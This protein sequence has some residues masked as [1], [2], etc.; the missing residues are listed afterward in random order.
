MNPEAGTIIANRFQLVRE[1][2]RG[3]MGTV[4][5]AHHLTLDVP[6]AVKF[7]T[8]EAAREPNYAARFELEARADRAAPEPAHRPRPRLR[9]VGRASPSSRWSCLEGEDLAVAPAPRQAP[10]RRRDPPHRRPGRARR[11]RARTPPASS[12]ATSSPRTSSSPREDDDEVVKVLD[13]GIAKFEGRAGPSHPGRRGP[14]HARL[15]EPRAGALRRRRSTPAPTSGRSASS[16]SSA[17]PG[18]LAFDG[19][20]LADIFA[21]I[22]VEPYAR[23]QPGRARPAAGLRRVVR[24]RH[25]AATR[26]GASPTRARCRTPSRARSA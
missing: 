17:S 7:M 12:T 22:L 20:S 26:R 9:P 16:P 21:R 18:R 14:R 10:R 13:F 15:H 24:P 25:V 11:S 5:L 19:A 1:L 2:G 6:C 4:W 23:P 8:A 3:T